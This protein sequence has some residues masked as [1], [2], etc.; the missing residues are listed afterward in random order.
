MPYTAK[1][2]LCSKAHFIMTFYTNRNDVKPMFGVITQMMMIFMRSCRAIIALKQSRFNQFTSPDFMIY[3]TIGFYAF[4]ITHTI[5]FIASFLRILAF[6]TCIIFATYFIANI[7][8][9]FSSTV[10]LES[11]VFTYFANIPVA[12]F[13]VFVFV[14]FRELL[15]LFARSTFSSYSLFKHLLLLIRSK[16]LGPVAAHTAVGS[17]YYTK[18]LFPVK[19]NFRKIS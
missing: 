10:F 5:D 15:N 16:C 6:F 3:F 17:L 13:T 4:W 8:T 9:M 12:V 18:Y 2:R 11:F 19:Y 14:K 1:N 7:F